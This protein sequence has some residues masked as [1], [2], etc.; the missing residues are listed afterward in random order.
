MS[1]SSSIMAAKNAKVKREAGKAASEN[2]MALMSTGITMSESAKWHMKHKATCYLTPR[3]NVV[4]R[5]QIVD[6]YNEV[7]RKISECIRN[8][9]AIPRELRHEYRS[10]CERV[11]QYGLQQ[12]V[13]LS[14]Q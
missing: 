2:M 4:I 7:D 10:I 3:G 5:Q 6:K 1:K 9:V 12:E 8:K 11:N 13:K 14:V